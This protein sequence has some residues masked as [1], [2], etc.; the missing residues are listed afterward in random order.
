M[1]QAWDPLGTEGMGPGQDQLGFVVPFSND[2]ILNATLSGFHQSGMEA[3]GS[4]D[5]R[6]SIWD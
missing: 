3:S 1:S 6:S 2:V 5:Y 4:I